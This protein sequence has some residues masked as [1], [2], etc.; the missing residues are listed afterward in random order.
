MDLIVMGTKGATGLK[1][2]LFGSHTIHVLKN[3]KCPV[4][5]IPSGFSFEA[6]REILFPTDY[7]VNY[8]KKHVQPIL[9]ISAL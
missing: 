7:E 5:V 8:K 3:T 2:V 6:P 9:N 1:E 4:I